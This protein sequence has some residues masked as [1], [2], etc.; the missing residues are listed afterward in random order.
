LTASHPEGSRAWVVDVGVGETPVTTLELAGALGELRPA[1]PL[2]AVEVDAERA[3]RARLF[4]R[5]RFE[6]RSGG[7]ALPLREGEAARLV[8][9]MNV[10]RGMRPGEVPEAHAALGDRLLP[11]GLLVEGTSDRS[12]DVLTAHLTRRGPAGLRREALLFFTNGRRGFAPILFRDHLPRDLRREVR[13]G[14]PV[15]ELFVAWTAAW[16]RVRERG[17]REPCAA[18]AASAELLSLADPGVD[19]G[20]ARRG[21]LVWAQQRAP[22]L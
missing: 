7:F 10:L 19:A 13:P 20:H 1:P 16:T 12:G 22:M 21:Y 8:R 6:V 3:E 15:Y 17:V 4:A 14:H 11:G 2:L 9:C 5:G 18:F